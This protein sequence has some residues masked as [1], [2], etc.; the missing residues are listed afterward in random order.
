MSDKNTLPLSKPIKAH[1]EEISSLTFRDMTG[2]DLLDVGSAPFMNDE[3][4]RIHMNFAVT[5]D[6]IVRL[7]GIPPSSV[8]Q[9]APADIMAAYAMVARFFGAPVKTSKK[10]SSATSS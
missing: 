7:A 8:K 4:G 2:E 10:P 5:G 3:K 6:Y 9:M 1:G